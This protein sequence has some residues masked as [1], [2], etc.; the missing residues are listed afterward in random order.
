MPPTKLHKQTMTTNN[1]P[2]TYTETKTTKHDLKPPTK[3]ITYTK[4]TL[5][6]KT[7]PET[8]AK[9]NPPLE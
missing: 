9:N 3:G 1:T 2:Y 4:G 7:T 6:I 5:T 8:H